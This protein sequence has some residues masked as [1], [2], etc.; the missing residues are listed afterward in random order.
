MLTNSMLRWRSFGLGVAFLLMG[1][2]AHADW[3]STSSAQLVL[4]VDAASGTADAVGAAYAIQGN[5]LAGTPVLN[6]G[7]APATGLSLQ[8]LNAG[9]AFQLTMSQKTADTVTTV[10]PNG[11]LPAYSEI[12]ISQAGSAG[13]LAGS[14]T[15]PT[16]GAA[17]AGGPG[18]SATL[19]QSNT[20]SV[21]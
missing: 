18:T 21:F 1:A 16:T 20:F 10:S 15:S 9:A 3:S 6:N 17:T 8:P 7:V 11:S 12:S 4:R 2:P 5:G 19:T 14:V 13:T